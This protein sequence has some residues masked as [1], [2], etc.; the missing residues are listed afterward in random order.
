VQIVEKSNLSV[1][2]TL[3]KRGIPRATLYRRY[4]L[5]SW[6]GIDALEEQRSI[7][8]VFMEPR[9]AL[10]EAQSTTKNN[11]KSRSMWRFVNFATCIESP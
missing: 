5:Y 8:W 1:L 6:G 3:E 2:P 4:D 11:A 7:A 10:S 9:R